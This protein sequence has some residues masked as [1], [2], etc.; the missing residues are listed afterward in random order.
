MPALANP[1][2]ELFAQELAKGK[3]Q[4]EAHELA[5]YK[6][7]RGNASSL[8]QDKSI[9]ERVSE[10]QAERA[11]MDREA[12]KQATEAL[13]IDKQWVMARLIDNATQ[14][15][16]LEDFGPSNKALELLGKEL[17]MFIDRKSI[18]VKNDPRALTDAELLAIA[19]ALEGEGSEGD[20]DEEGDQT[21]VH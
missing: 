4:I 19:A 16:S 2:H 10:I 7:H 5:G 1:K 11:E 13:A 20:P 3:S 12:T 6:P 9:L 8:A 17:G 14:A 21:V 15:A 18:D